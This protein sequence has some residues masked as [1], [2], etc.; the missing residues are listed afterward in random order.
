MPQYEYVNGFSPNRFLPSSA[1][2]YHL[3]GQKPLPS[4]LRSAGTHSALS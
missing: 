3:H 2:T 1:T 4:N